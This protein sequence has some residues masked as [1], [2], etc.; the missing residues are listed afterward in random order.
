[1]QIVGAVE[2]AQRTEA[3]L[4]AA[5]GKLGWKT[6][7]C[8]AQGDPSK[9]QTCMDNLLAQGN[10]AIFNIA[11]DPT[12]IKA[13]LAKAKAKN[14]PVFTCC[15]ATSQ[16][17]AFTGYYPPPEAN[18]SDLLNTYLFKRLDEVQGDKSIAT[19]LYSGG[20][21]AKLREDELHKALKSHPDVKVVDEG[22]LDLKDPDGSAGTLAA[23]LLTKHPK[24][25]AIWTSF[26][27]PVGSVGKLV[28]SK[29]A[30]KQF[31]DRP[32]VVGFNGNKPTM[33]LIRKGVIDAVSDSDFVGDAWMSVD[34]A[35]EYFAR[36]T[37]PSNDGN[38]RD[39]YPID[40]DDAK[41]L[42]KDN[43]PADGQYDHG[44]NDYTAFFTAKWQAEFT[45]VAK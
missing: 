9:M 21:F 14:V 34:Q 11:V 32:L 5:L 15:G 8:D 3:G 40:I 7:V 42:T 6:T 36:K 10:Q 12:V 27:S 20:L 33:D 38:A 23:S 28:A 39:A 2:G 17:D 4:K 37:K 29:Y 26:D 16:G 30:G 45:N 44:K 19:L 41:L 43:L 31:P 18:A 13:Q 25:S 35:A 22:Q 24:L 1:M